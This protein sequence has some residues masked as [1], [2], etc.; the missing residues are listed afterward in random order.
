MRP[1]ISNALV[2]ALIATVCLVMLVLI[3]AG[4]NNFLSVIWG[5]ALPILAISV[6]AG[7]ARLLFARG[8]FA[9][10]AVCGV[11]IAVA[12]FVIVLAAAVT[13]M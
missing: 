1:N 13:N 12:G 8:G 9:V 10:S 11:V 5:S 6:A 4:A 2:S 7:V 3:L